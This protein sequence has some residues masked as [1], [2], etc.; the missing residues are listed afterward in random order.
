M[1]I[2][3]MLSVFLLIYEI[4][5][6][7]GKAG[8]IFEKIVVSIFIIEYLLRAWLYNDSHKIIIAQYEK[9]EYLEV[10]F[11]LLRVMLAVVAKKIEYV[12]TPLAI[13]DLLAIL[14]SYRPLRILRF[15]LLF[16]LLKIFRYS[17]SIKMFT[18]VL[19]G[20]RFELLTLATFLGFLI[21]I[22]STAIYMF[23][24]QKTGGQI[25][26][27]FDAIYWSIVTLST[28]GYGDITPQ[29]TGGR[30]ITLV[31]IIFG[32]GVLAFFTSIIVSAFN[33]KMHELR[34]SHTY[35]AIEKFDDFV[36]ICGFGRVGQEITRQMRRDRQA[37]VVIDKDE[38]NASLGKC[39]GIPVI[40]DDASKNQVLELSG[41]NH[42]ANTV[43]CTTGDDVINVYITLTSRNLN[44]T[45]NIISRANCKQNV[46]KL[47]QAG[48]DHVIQPFE[49]AGLLAAE[50]IGQPVA[51]EAILGIMH[52]ERGLLL[53]ALNV[54]PDSF[55]TG[56]LIGDIDFEHRKMRLVGVISNNPKHHRHKNRY[57]VRNQHFY[58]NPPQHFVLCG[59][60]IL[61]LLGRNYSIEHFGDQLK[62]SSLKRE[63]YAS[64][65]RI[66]RR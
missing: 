54:L 12:F 32:L 28:V 11:Q 2:L 10:P 51:F 49:I 5:A 6:E 3:V 15:F 29:S 23:E 40:H 7:L 1:I 16:R 35:A 60:D 22:A 48:A 47:L 37:I 52:H 50:Y 62:K 33:E 14:P 4:G 24:N 58:F 46:K 39:Q 56:R 18:D 26:N 25:E 43:I 34:E 19:F 55:I 59:G 27:L 13:I 38:A 66:P 63:L 31:L 8:A 65:S 44:K 36:I 17:R 53:E 57:R 64:R 42:G 61:V 20:K 30:F 45:V 41:I 9:S 21:F